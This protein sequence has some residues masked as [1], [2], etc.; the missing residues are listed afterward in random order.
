MEETGY[1]RQ[2]KR[3]KVLATNSTIDS[4]LDDFGWKLQKTWLWLA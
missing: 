1:Y 3:E 4:S 2:E